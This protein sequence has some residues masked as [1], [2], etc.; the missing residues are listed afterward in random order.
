MCALREKFGKDGKVQ[1]VLY[2][3]SFQYP[4]I[5]TLNN[6]LFVPMFLLFLILKFRNFTPICPNEHLFSW[7]LL[8]GF[9]NSFLSHVGNIS[10]SRNG[11]STQLFPL[12]HFDVNNLLK[13]LI[14]IFFS[15]YC[16]FE[17]WDHFNHLK[18]KT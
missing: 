15:L 11:S 12:V 2:Y 1:T 10:A 4:K 14:L 18:Q 9:L 3:F 8:T 6:L 17:F 5:G 13:M 16:I 7:I